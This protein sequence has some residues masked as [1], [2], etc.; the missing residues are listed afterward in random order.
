MSNIRTLLGGCAVAALMLPLATVAQTIPAD[1]TAPVTETAP[2]EAKDI[3]VT[4]TIAFRNRTED[5]NP[6]LAYDLDYFQRFEPVSVGEM[7]KRVPGVTFTSDVLEYDGPQFRGL[8]AGYTQVLINGRRAP[9]GQA[10][11]SFFVD[12]IPA[13]LVERIEI[14]RSP[15][16]D[17]PSEGVA[18]SL[19]IVTKEAATF[20]GGFAKA[21]ALINKDGKFRPSLGAAYAG[22]IGED[23]SYWGALNYQE[24][25]NPKKKVSLR[26]DDENDGPRDAT[27]ADFN[28]TELQADTRD[29]SD[30]SGSAEIRHDFGDKGF[31]RFQGFFVDTDREEFE[32]SVTYD[33][34]DLDFD[35]IET[36]L[37]DINQQTYTLS[38]DARI[39][40]G[41]SLELGLAAGW[42]GY[43][44]D[45]DSTVM[46]GDNEDDL[47]DLELD[48]VSNVTIKDDEYTGTINLGFGGEMA[49]FK[50]GVD[51]LRKD[52]DGVNDGD[53]QTNTFKIKEER[54][55]PYARVTLTPTPQLTVDAGL[56]YEITRRT[57]SGTAVASA[58]YETETLNPSLHVRYAPTALDQFR[59][60]GARTV[61]RPNYDFISPYED[62]ETPG[63]DDVTIGNPRLRN[64]KAWGLDAGYERRLGGR[65]VAG[66]NFFYRDITDVIELVA[67]GE[68]GDGQRF[69]PQNIGDGKTWGFEVDLSTPLTA[70]G[71]PDTGVFAN[72]TYLDSEVTDPFTGE[73]RRFNN[74]PHHVY[75]VGFI[76]TV[77]SVDASFGAT[78]SGRSKATESNFDETVELKYDPDLEAFVEKRIGKNFVLRFSVQDILRRT[79]SETFRKY[80]GNSVAEILANRRAGDIDEFELER[81]N[82]GPLYQVTIRAAF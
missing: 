11:R 62:E 49:R 18:G 35:G 45:T 52:R 13:E 48:D 7:L 46:V 65:G 37:E 5:V 60:S 34:S 44:E 56:R 16:A 66:I 14:V 43:R 12:R 24:R 47:D 77:T 67:I 9:G 32:S 73:K 29:G 76:Q 78:V 36:Q 70:I 72:Y 59:V 38:S 22:R 53:F 25:R 8:P 17:Q 69:T 42:S 79:K 39:P 55:D 41:G 40:L 19:N 6:V 27:N 21:G 28:N 61:R 63:D 23:T 82:A 71:L 15:R 74:Q 75:N 80:D 3:I 58:D 4:G 81:E 33:G 68:N 51:L 2:D 20:E 30:L 54:Y 26:F 64:E 1:S 57:V 50:L 10:D 31:V